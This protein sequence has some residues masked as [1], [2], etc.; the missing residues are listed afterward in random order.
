MMGNDT[1]CRCHA[2]KGSTF[3]S[4]PI[5]SEAVDGTPTK[6]MRQ[7]SY[8]GT[9]NFCD[10]CNKQI[11]TFDSSPAGKSNL[12]ALSSTQNPTE[13]GAD[14]GPTSSSS[15]ERSDSDKVM[16]NFRE[17]LYFWKEY[18]LKR[19]RDRLSLEFSSHI[20]F[21]F[22]MYVVGKRFYYLHTLL[23]KYLSNDFIFRFSEL[24]SA[25]DGSPTALLPKPIALPRSYYNCPSRAHN[26]SSMNIINFHYY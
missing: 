11:S 1:T 24:L 15:T 14:A 4:K 12:G 9:L 17:L 2:T 22:W 23:V 26:S 16:I 25:D 21:K 18:Y 13:H 19:G 10:V 5:S 6:D 3:H 7:G 20:P 8:L